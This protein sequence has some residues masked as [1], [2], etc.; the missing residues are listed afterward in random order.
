[1]KRI[2]NSSNVTCHFCSSAMKHYQLQ[3]AAETAC[4]RD[5][6]NVSVHRGVAA[7]NRPGLAS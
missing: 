3:K 6:S 2:A 1:M 4:T 7:Q 5:G